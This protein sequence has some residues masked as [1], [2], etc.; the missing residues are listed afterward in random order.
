MQT[1]IQKT[2]PSFKLAGDIERPVRPGTRWLFDGLD[3]LGHETFELGRAVRI[4]GLAGYLKTDTDR[5]DAQE[6]PRP[7]D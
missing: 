2:D 3:V 1:D 7:S 6:P 4:R 5:G